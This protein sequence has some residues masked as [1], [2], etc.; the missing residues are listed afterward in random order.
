MA[1]MA[2]T[3]VAIGIDHAFVGED[4]VGDHQLAN[5]EV[6]VVHSVVLQYGD[7]PPQRTPASFLTTTGSGILALEY[8][9]RGEILKDTPL[10][11]VLSCAALVGHADF[12]HDASGGRIGCH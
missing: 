10:L 7:Y 12:L 1:R 8:A 4:T 9:V 2:H 6:Q 5:M 3:D 11:Y